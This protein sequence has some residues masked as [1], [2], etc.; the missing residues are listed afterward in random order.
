MSQNPLLGILLSLK[1]GRSSIPGMIRLLSR[2]ALLCFTACPVLLAQSS[3]TFNGRIVDQAGAVV[4]EATVTARNTGTG[5]TRTTTTNS[6]G[7]YTLPALE[8]GAYDLKVEKTGFAAAEK[9]EVTLVTSATL[10]LDFSLAVAGTTQQVE[11]TGEV[12]LVETSRSDVSDSLRL[13]EVQNLPIIN[14]NFTGLVQLVPGARPAPVVNT[15]KTTMGNGMSFSGG[16][17][18]NVN[19]VVDGADDRDDII[20]GPVQNITIEGIQEFN[21]I[22]HRFSAEYGGAT[23]AVVLVTTKSGA[24]K[25]HGSAFAFGRNDALTAIDYFTQQSGFPKT[26]YDHEQFGGSLGGPIRKDRWFIFGAVERDRENFVQS[27]TPKAVSEA[28]VF[29]K[30]FPSLGVIPSASVPQPLGDTMYTIKSDYQINSKNSIFVRWA[31]QLNHRVNAQ[32]MQTQP[33]LGAANL[34]NN[35]IWNITGGYTW[36]ISNN[37]VNQFTVDGG[38]YHHYLYMTV[39]NTPVIRNLR[40]PSTNLGRWMGTDQF[41]TQEKVRFAD[42]FSH[43]IGKHALKVGGQFSYYPLVDIKLAIGQCGVVSFFDDPST[44]V[45]NLNGKYPQGFLTP[46]AV[47]GVTVGSCSAGGATPPGQGVYG[48]SGYPEKLMSLYAQDDYRITPRLTFNLGARYDLGFNFYNQAENG[49]NRAYNALLAIHSAYGALPSASAKDVAPRVGFA[50]DLRG[51]GKSVLR[52][53]YGIFFTQELQANVFSLALLDKPT[54]NLSSAYVNSSVGVGQLANYVYGVSPLPPGPSTAPT[55]LPPGAATSGSWIAPW[56]R[57]P[58][59][60]QFQIGYTRQIRTNTAISADYTHILGIHEFSTRQINPI[61]GLW[62][63]NRGAVP[64]GTRRLAPSFGAA[65]GDPNILGGISI[66]SSDNR[67]QYNELIVHLEHRTRRVA[68][69]ASYTL[70]YARAFG[71]IIS[72]GTGGTTPGSG[73][74]SAVNSDQPFAPG[75]WGPSW[76]DERHRAVL[77]GVFTMPWGI[78]A[79]PIF[80]VGSARPYTLLDGTDCNKD[81]TNNDRAYLNASTGAIVACNTPAAAN[82]VP[83]AVNSQRGDPTWDLDLRVSKF[84]NLGS[85][86]RTLSVFAEFY[87][88]TNKINFGNIYNGNARSSTFRQPNGYLAGLPTSRQLQL[89][90]RFTF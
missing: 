9:K 42:N 58:Y 76:L 47:S 20:G 70:A 50:Y 62:D 37:S 82:A 72:G 43:Q 65:L 60:Q 44:I 45:G 4:P 64:T 3:G 59:T 11:V 36:V 75:E 38:D 33:D 69:Q 63:P 87:D 23:A 32:L 10:T 68:F 52:G 77:S 30:A 41:F 48:D 49:S 40:F 81:G 16:G 39:P 88:L 66:A 46:G 57:D 55:V 27:E 90:A 84:F 74:V 83:V 6:D 25:F 56:I 85:E 86:S 1:Q 15:S 71:G 2:V 28:L 80:Q 14:R 26:P 61:E 13:S 67:S 17:G 53:G 54:L 5:V 18:R 8:P 31:H 78:Q 35:R 51:D 73:G 12:P 21:V 7:L 29:A 24:N 79:A 89:G 22:T 19:V 34:N